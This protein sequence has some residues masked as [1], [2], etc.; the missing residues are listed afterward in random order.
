MDHP[1]TEEV[2]KEQDKIF[3]Y[4]RNLDTSYTLRRRKENYG[5]A[6]S[7]LTTIEEELQENDH[8][9]LLED[10]CVPLDGFF[11]YMAENIEKSRNDESISSVC[12][13]ITNCKF[14]PWGWA[15]WDNKWDYEKMSKDDVLEIKNLDKDLRHFLENNDV[16]DS[17]WSLSWLAHQYKN[18]QYS[19][20]PVK[21]LI[22]NIGLDDSGVHSSKKGYTQWLLSQIQKD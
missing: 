20:F 12:G 16:E 8:I 4:M 18:N 9:V 1:A 3:N 7:V 19:K 2:K 13:T 21:N 22:E 5:L 15:T 14:N 6:K 10:D 17:I 11:D